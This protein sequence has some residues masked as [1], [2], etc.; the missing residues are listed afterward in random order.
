[1]KPRKLLISPFRVIGRSVLDMPDNAPPLPVSPDRLPD[2]YYF[3]V[4]FDDNEEGQHRVTKGPLTADRQVKGHYA[5]AAER[6]REMRDFIRHVEL[7]PR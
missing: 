3:F 5:S 1:M 7:K 2:G 4:A 6:D